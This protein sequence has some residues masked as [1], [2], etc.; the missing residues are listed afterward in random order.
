MGVDVRAFGGL[1]GFATVSIRGSTSEQ[2]QI[3]LDGVLLSR[4]QGGSFNLA[5][6]P[7][8]Q[9][10][11][12]EVYR[13]LTPARFGAAAPG[14]VINLVS[15][16]GSAQP[17][18]TFSFGAGSFDTAEFAMSHSAPHALGDAL[19]S[20]YAQ[21]SAGDFS[22]L[23][24]NGTPLNPTDDEVVRRRNNQFFVAGGLA[25]GRFDLREA[26]VVNLALEGMA[27]TAGV[28]GVDALQ[29]TAAKLDSQRIFAKLDYERR[30]MS[31]RGRVIASAFVTRVQDEFEDPG[32]E[33]GLAPR[34][35]KTTTWTPGATVRATLALG[36]WQT[37]TALAEYRHDGAQ[38]NTLSLGR[39]ST[40]EVSRHNFAL[41]L[42]DQLSPF[43]ERLV[44]NPSVRFDL[45]RSAL[46]GGARD[47]V[48]H[49]EVSG[50]LGVRL[51]LTR[52][53]YFRVNGGRFFRAANLTELFG[54]T[55]LVRGNPRLRPELGYTVDAG[56]SFLYQGGG[57]LKR[58]FAEAAYF[59]SH[60]DELILFLLN[61]QGVA[62][63]ENL[64]AAVVRGVELQASAAL[65]FG[66]GLSAAY[67]HQRAL[68]ASA[69][70]TAG[71]LLPGRP[72]HKVTARA[73]FERG[74][75][76]VFYELIALDGNYVDRLNRVLLD[77]R[78]LHAAGAAWRP[79]PQ[80]TLSVELQN[81]TDNRA[82]DLYR[83]PLP[84]RAVFAKLSS[85]F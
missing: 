54:D 52:G 56:F 9:I 24:N 72:Q 12:V 57:L 5:D 53:L 33:L 68:D 35:V 43:G 17:R 6:V 67:T 55:G 26:G 58:L 48:T 44:L 10:E 39:A 18:T 11:R 30:F 47:A 79:L 71:N 34:E 15:R 8:S 28:A 40:S 22:F 42:E 16:S 60:T 77:A 38:Q 61:G 84:G 27:R 45:L 4:A 36:S 75:I 20:V 1:G 64:S 13:G 37:L 85:D 51:L 62:V 76:R 69:A 31:G 59:E 25:R 19:V 21:K 80:L 70:R 2:V 41:A 50:K 49:A 23:D 83:F 14:G 73:S 7:L 3:F 63:A 82:V 78:V 74:P 81:F 32:G 46:S 66:L 65:P 29:S